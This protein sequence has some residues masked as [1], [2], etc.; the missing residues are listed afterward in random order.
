MDPIERLN[1]LFNIDTGEPKLP[2]LKSRKFKDIIECLEQSALEVQYRRKN[3]DPD[4]FLDIDQETWLRDVTEVSDPS[5][6]E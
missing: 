2:F 5:R 6:Y 3:D 1:K 4:F